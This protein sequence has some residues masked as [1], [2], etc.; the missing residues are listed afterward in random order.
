MWKVVAVW[1]ILTLFVPSPP[2]AVAM[3]TGT[4]HMH[5]GAP[6]SEQAV[7]RSAGEPAESA[8]RGAAEAEDTNI[9]MKSDLSPSLADNFS[10]DLGSSLHWSDDMILHLVSGGKT[11]S[12]GTI[13]DKGL[14]SPVEV[15]PFYMDES[16]VTNHQYVEF[17][18]A[19]HERIEVE[20]GVVR[21][22]GEIWLILGEV[23][24]DYRPIVYQESGFVVSDVQHAAC[25][26]R[27]PP[28]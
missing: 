1:V 4:G 26:K 21:G 6:E 10:E 28:R 27:C 14:Q 15:N 16:P 7:G 11:P 25:R 18:N 3:M 22:D 20:N 13:P 23:K 8:L 2:S 9:E 24:D 12:N 5:R 19:A 17:L